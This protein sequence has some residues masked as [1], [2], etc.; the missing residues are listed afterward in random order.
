[1]SIRKVDFRVVRSLRRRLETDLIFNMPFTSTRRSPDMVIL[2]YGVNLRVE[3]TYFMDKHQL[4]SINHFNSLVITVTTGSMIY[5]TLF[6][7]I[8]VECENEPR[9]TRGELFAHANMLK[10]RLPINRD[11]RFSTPLLLGIIYWAQM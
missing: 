8:M 7:K 6:L 10:V 3:K 1:M 11:P 2:S 5:F 9:F 4:Y